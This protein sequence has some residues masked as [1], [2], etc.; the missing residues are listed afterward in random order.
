MTNDIPDNAATALERVFWRVRK[1]GRATVREVWTHVLKAQ[2]TTPEFAIRHAEVVNLVHRLQ[3]YI[4]SM[5]EGDRTRQRYEGD[6]VLWYSAVVCTDNWRSNSNASDTLIAEDKVNL[7]GS[8]GEILT[9]R[10]ELEKRSTA[11]GIE[12]LKQSLADWVTLLDEVDLPPDLAARIRAQVDQIEFLLSEIDT[13][14]LEPIAE[15]G[16]TLFGL[17]FSV[18]KVVGVVGTVTGAMNSLFEFITQVSVGDVG[19]AFNALTGLFSSASEVFDL[20]KAEQ[21]A[22]ESK[23]PK[24][25][26]QKADSDVIEGEIVD[27]D[28]PESPTPEDGAQG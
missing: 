12:T 6:I 14:G 9:Q 4:L 7:L 15:H 5:P 16:R 3:L 23:K 21:K 17:G 11:P 10:A 13:Y 18:I 8:L 22:I 19:P 2:P 27:P 26:T 1:S 28:P 25:I 20:A 24:A